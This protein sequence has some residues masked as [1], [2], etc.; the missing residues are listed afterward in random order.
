MM[1]EESTSSLGEPLA[2]L[3][4]K[5]RHCSSGLCHILIP[6]ILDL[7]PMASLWTSTLSFCR[8]LQLTEIITQ[9]PNTPFPV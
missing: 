6:V 3:M 7:N 2:E 8:L 5:S 1:C 9:K 4:E